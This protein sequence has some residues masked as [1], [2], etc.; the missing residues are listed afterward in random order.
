MPM[1]MANIILM[2]MTT[3]IGMI[4]VVIMLITPVITTIE[5]MLDIAVSKNPNKHKIIDD[6]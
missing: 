3:T 1:T 5:T 6:E 2:M 4:M